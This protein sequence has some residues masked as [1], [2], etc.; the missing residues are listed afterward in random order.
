MKQ[1]SE[2]PGTHLTNMASSPPFGGGQVPVNCKL[3]KTDRPIQWKC[4][5]CSILMCGYCKENV[6][7]QFKNALYHKIIRREEIG[8]HTEE[9]DFTNIKCDEHAEQSSCLYCNMCEILVCPTCVAKVHKKHDLIEICDAYKIKV[10]RLKNEQ[11]KMQKSNSK[12]NMK[13]IQ[14]KKLVL[15][16]N[17]KYSKV[18]EDLLKH[19]KTVKDQ[20]E[21]HFKELKNKLEQNHET[22]LISVK[23]DLNAISLFTTQKEDKINEV[24]DCIDLSNASEF[25]KEVMKI[26][27]FTEIQEPRTKSS[28]NSSPKFV[29]GNINQSIIGSLQDDGNLSA[30]INISLVINNVYQTELDA[31]VDVSPCLDQSIWISSG[32]YGILHRV[33][34][35]G[36]NL[37]VMSECNIKIFRMAV[38]PS[39][40][41]ILSVEG[42]TRLQQINNTGELTDSVY[43]VTPFYPN[44]NHVVSDNKLIVGAYGFIGNELKRSAV[45]VMNKKGDKETVYEH[46]EHNQPL[47][48][49]TLRITSTSTGNIHV[50]DKI[51]GDWSG[52]VVVLGQEG[53]I[54][55]Q[56]T[57]HSTINKSESFKPGDIVTTPSDNVVV[58]DPVNH[59]LHIL[60]DNGH[61]IS[62]FNTE[63][64]GIK[65]P[66]SFAF[67]TTGK[68]YIGCGRAAGS[69]TKEAKLYKINIEGF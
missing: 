28:Y 11:S 13:R 62:Y 10:E 41:L 30:E 61:L 2:L 6:H 66:F 52:K 1:G 57:G 25:F 3:C 21:K 43:D 47:F 8:L 69:Q 12:M 67:N 50:V 24:Q 16:E 54:I 26:E 42:K 39:N 31:I 22:V 56:Y 19:E 51:S 46:D 45:F 40:Q 17:S 38:T 7:S 37:K 36:N 63:D 49:Y 68:L 60:N 48:T 29:P 34:P 9:L 35:E 64:I 32:A 55:N 20:V 14:L 59:I 5:D 33:K 4:M 53:H 27:K 44:A 18:R 15:V 58:M 23:S 65:F